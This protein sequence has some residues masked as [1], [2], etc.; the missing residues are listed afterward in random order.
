MFEK[1]CKS[2]P[3][4]AA[5][6]VIPTVVYGAVLAVGAVTIVKF[7]AK[8]MKKGSRRKLEKDLK[9]CGEDVVAFARDACEGVCD[10]MSECDGDAE[11]AEG[12]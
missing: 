7:V 6:S 12:L 10:C 9:R 8:K 11:S 3:R 2:A 4:C 5:M 1:K